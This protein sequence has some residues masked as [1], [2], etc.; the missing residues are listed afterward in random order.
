M[1]VRAKKPRSATTSRASG[2]PSIR[3]GKVVLSEAWPG[4]R[5]RRAAPLAP[6]APLLGEAADPGFGAAEEIH[7]GGAAALAGRAFGVDLD[8]RLDDHPVAA[9]GI[10][11]SK[12]RQQRRAGEAG[13]AR[14]ADGDRLAAAEARRLDHLVALGGGGDDGDHLA[15]LQGAHHPAHGSRG[16]GAVEDDALRQMPVLGDAADAIEPGDAETGLRIAVLRAA[17]MRDPVAGAVQHLLGGEAV[18]DEGRHPEDRPPALGQRRAGD[19]PRLRGQ[20]RAASNR[21]PR[22]GDPACGA[23]RPPP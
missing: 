1:M 17:E 22:P 8:R 16:C 4:V 12:E 15:R 18:E 7:G 2:K 21:G 14:G 6:G 23:R 5:T 13:K 3:V 20:P 9:I 10:A 11:H 19:A